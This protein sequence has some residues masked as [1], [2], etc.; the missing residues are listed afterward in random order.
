M[1]LSSNEKLVLLMLNN[2][3]KIGL[4]GCG[5]LGMALA[6]QLIL[7][8]YK[9]KGSTTRLDKLYDLKKSGIEA[10]QIN[11]NADSLSGDFESFLNELEV[12][13]ITIP[14]QFSKPQTNLYESLNFVFQNHDLSFLKKLIYISST[15]VFVD[16]PD[17]TYDE[18]SK[19]NNESPRGKHLIALEALIKAQNQ[20]QNKSILRYGGLIKHNGRHPVHFLSGKENISNPEAPV[21]LIEQ[22]D[23]VD[24]LIKIIE[25]PK[26]FNIYHGVNP[27]HPSRVNYYTQKAK[28]LKLKPPI[29]DNTEISVG[30]I[31]QSKVTQD[32]LNFE[33]KSGI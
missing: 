3:K 4:L 10:Y 15:G 8:G 9:V 26:H 13:V 24:L 32:I 20:I 14:P 6:K 19:P 16:G 18:N 5:W 28:T 12:L 30:K 17:K 29:F 21:N 31:V 33:Y 11:L 23:A 2:L 22:K 1:P 25:K 27:S 7:K